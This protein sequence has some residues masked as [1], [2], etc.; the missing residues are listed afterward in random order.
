[1]NGN[2]TEV[3]KKCPILK[4]W[5]TSE[6]KEACAFSC[7]IFINRGG[8]NQKAVVC[9]KDAIVIMLSEINIKTQT[10]EVRGIQLPNSF[11]G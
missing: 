6:I 9:F 4:E 1:M 10:P 3:K 11:R 2:N 8:L 5:C 7:E